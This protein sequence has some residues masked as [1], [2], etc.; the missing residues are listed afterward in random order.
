MTNIKDF[1]RGDTRVINI[2][3]F[4]PDG[5]TPLNL[6]GATVYFTVN[7]N[8]S[9]TDDTSAAF[10][11]STTSHTAP[12]LGQTSITIASA[13]TQSLTPGVYWY[14]VQ[15]KDASGNITSLKQAEFDINADITRTNT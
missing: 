11:K 9:P 15:I 14:D 4:Q 2:N 13:D 3:C 12:L 7:S 6:T 8:Q 5:V 1:I 10:Q